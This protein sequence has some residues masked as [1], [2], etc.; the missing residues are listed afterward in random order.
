MSLEHFFTDKA[1]LL[2]PDGSVTEVE[3]ANGKQFSL[4][5][6]QGYVGGYIEPLRCRGQAGAW[7]IVN[8]EG[9][10]QGLPYNDLATLIMRSLIRPDDVIVG[11]ALL[12]KPEQL[13]TDE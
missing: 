5:E 2:K 7:L 9:K 4:E 6:L 13:N 3:P 12:C 10:N 11:P 1:K 8:E